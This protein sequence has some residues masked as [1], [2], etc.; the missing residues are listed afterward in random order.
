MKTIFQKKKKVTLSD[1]KIH[2][3]FVVIKQ[4][5]ISRIS[6]YRIVCRKKLLY[7]WSTDYL[8][9]CLGHSFG[10]MVPENRNTYE[11]KKQTTWYCT[12]KLDGCISKP[13]KLNT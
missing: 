4:F 2:C 12:E 13:K 3:K 5:N 8:Q 6:I 9:R 7:L 11:K 10:E 1:F